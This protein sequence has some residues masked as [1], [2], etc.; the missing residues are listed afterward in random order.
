[1]FVRD[2]ERKA[3]IGD[4]D[5]M[6]RNL[7]EQGKTMHP[8]FFTTGV[9]HG[10]FRLIRIPR[11]GVTMKAENNNVD[12]AAIEVFNLWTKREVARGT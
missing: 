11:R 9:F 12:T 1:M 5:T 3:S 7:Q 10:S 2:I 8:E 4:Y 6:I